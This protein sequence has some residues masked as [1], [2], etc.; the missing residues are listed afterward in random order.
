ML[1]R[2]RGGVEPSYMSFR[3]MCRN[4]SWLVCVFNSL[5][6]AADAAPIHKSCRNIL[7][8]GLFGELEVSCSYCSYKCAFPPDS[9]ESHE[10]PSLQHHVCS[11]IKGTCNP[12]S[13]KKIFLLCGAQ[14]EMYL[15][16]EQYAICFKCFKNKKQCHANV[17][18]FGDD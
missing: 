6:V 15:A 2:L 7:T 18:P 4:V 10:V 12:F 16:D 14:C 5:L 13:C 3:N 8:K 17:R 9:I 1:R 11:W